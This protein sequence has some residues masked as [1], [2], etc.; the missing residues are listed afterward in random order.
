MPRGTVPIPGRA[1]VPWFSAVSLPWPRACAGPFP[2]VPSPSSASLSARAVGTSAAGPSRG[3]KSHP[4][5]AG[6]EQ[7][8]EGVRDS[9][10]TQGTKAPRAVEGWG[11]RAEQQLLFGSWCWGHSWDTGTRVPWPPLH[12]LQPPRATSPT[13]LRF[14]TPGGA[15]P[16]RFYSCKARRGLGS[17][18]KARRC[19]GARSLQRGDPTP[20]PHPQMLQVELPGCP[21]AEKSL[22][23]FF[24]VFPTLCRFLGRTKVPMSL[25]P[26]PCPHH[27]PHVSSA[28]PMSPVPSPCP[29]CQP[30]APGAPWFW[31]AAGAAEL[32]TNKEEMGFGHRPPEQRSRWSRLC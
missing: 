6:D 10:R 1:T 23:F 15:F 24:L 5:A 11:A 13:A 3:T 16:P 31:G 25:L 8:R 2:A 32:Q 7:G 20:S 9:G 19:W 28:I 21:P 30:P 12:L 4:R 26:S 27:H 18:P 22:F 17:A 29:Q 14:L